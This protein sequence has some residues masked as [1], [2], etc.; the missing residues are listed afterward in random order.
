MEYFD[1]DESTISWASSLFNG[2]SFLFGPIIGALSNKYG[3]RPVVIAGSV[4]CC[5]G[6]GLSALSSNVLTLIFTIGVIGGFGAC[7]VALPSDVSVGYYFE[8]KRQGHVY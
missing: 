4:V 2:L 7:L 1:S 5:I 6:L 8:T 3:F